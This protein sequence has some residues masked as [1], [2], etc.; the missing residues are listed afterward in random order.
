MGYLQSRKFQRTAGDGAPEL[1]GDELLFFIDF[2][3]TRFATVF[4][5][6]FDLILLLV[7]NYLITW[8]LNLLLCDMGNHE[9][10][11]I[12]VLEQGM[13]DAVH[14]ESGKG[15]FSCVVQALLSDISE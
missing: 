1:S 5:C 9:D 10:G 3:Y 2:L 13:K 11:K 15:Y 12:H 6:F 4:K 8:W 14:S 7:V